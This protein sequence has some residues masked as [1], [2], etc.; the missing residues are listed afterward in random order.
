MS[1]YIGTYY[2][3]LVYYKAMLN[4]RVLI[5]YSIIIRFEKNNVLYQYYMQ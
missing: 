5:M 3:L 1:K 2:I 4:D